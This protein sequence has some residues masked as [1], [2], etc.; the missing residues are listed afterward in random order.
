MFTLFR[1]LSAWGRIVIALFA[2]GGED[3]NMRDDG[4]RG[5]MGKRVMQTRR[6]R[7]ELNG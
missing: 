4:D 2:Q 3:G 1:L 7:N 5:R 6:E